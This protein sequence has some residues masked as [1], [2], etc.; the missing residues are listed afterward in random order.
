MERI[1]KFKAIDGKEFLEAMECVKYEQLIYE[2]Q[3]ILSVLKPL[4][5][6]DGCAF[7]NGES[8]LQQDKT[9]VKL[10]KLQLLRL[11]K[12]YINHK[13]IDQTIDDD[14]VD[15]SWVAR[16]VGDYGIRPLCDAWHRI[17]CTDKEFREWGQPYFVKHPEAS[18]AMQRIVKN[19]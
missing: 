17:S 16:L 9:N 12:Q 14:K 13:W 7:A 18:P 11:M 5:K 15:P 8:F 10:A 4:P 3:Q 2:V 6:D 1:I 19:N